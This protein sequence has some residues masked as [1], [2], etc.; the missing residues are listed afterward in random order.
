VAILLPAPGTVLDDEL[1]AEAVRQP[2][3]HEA[4]QKID[5]AAGGKTGDD[6]YRPRR[7]VLRGRNAR[8]RRQSGKSRRDFQKFPTQKCHGVISAALTRF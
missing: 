6:L 5:R 8:Q 7:I 3:R 2:L 1:L 4:R